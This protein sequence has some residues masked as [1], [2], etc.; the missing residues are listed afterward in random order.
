MSKSMEPVNL[1][2]LAADVCRELAL[3]KEK[4]IELTYEGAPKVMVRGKRRLLARL[5]KNLIYNAYC[6]SREHIWVFLGRRDGGV[7][8]S[9]A[10]DGIQGTGLGPSMVR[11]IAWLHGGEVKVA[12]EPGKGST[13]T[14]LL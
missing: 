5:L 2:E 14:V 13:F 11:E 4:E 7:E 1:S 3:L 12:S 8:L 10:Y 9:V 6:Y